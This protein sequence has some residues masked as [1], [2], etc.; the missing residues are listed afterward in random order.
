MGTQYISSSA[1]TAERQVRDYSMTELVR[2]QGRAVQHSQPGRFHVF[3]Q[4]ESKD[5]I[6]HFLDAGLPLESEIMQSELISTLQGAHTSDDI[7]DKKQLLVEELSYTLLARR[8]GTNPIYY[9]V[10]P[11]SALDEKLS[12][13]ADYILQE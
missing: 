4:A 6:S 7:A 11:S 2:M 3:C 9:D 1:G 12:R 10:D 13:I 5:T 8:L